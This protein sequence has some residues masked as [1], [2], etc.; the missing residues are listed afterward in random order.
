MVSCTSSDQVMFASASRSLSMA[1]SMDVRDYCY[2]VPTAQQQS[3][4]VL[5]L[6]QAM[7]TAFSCQ[8]PSTAW[9]LNGESDLYL[10]GLVSTVHFAFCT[11]FEYWAATGDHSA[12]H[13]CLA[14]CYILTPGP[15]TLSH[16]ILLFT[17]NV[18]LTSF[19]PSDV[20]A[21]PSR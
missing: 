15:R 12:I 5:Q 4:A 3:A 10:G 8:H 17:E 18:F 13:R 20:Q 21:G 11:F 1:P 7:F 6:A 19:C 16:E 14:C 9:G 2:A